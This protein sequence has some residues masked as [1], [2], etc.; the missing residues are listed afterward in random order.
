MPE[1]S[2]ARWYRKNRGRWNQ[3]RRERYHGD[4][5]FRELTLKRVRRS[6]AKTRRGEPSGPWTRCAGKPRPANRRLAPEPAPWNPAILCH[7]IGALTEATGL[8][9]ATLVGWERRGII[10]LPTFV[11]LAGKKRYRRYS[12]DY[13]RI[14]VRCVEKGRA[15]AWSTRR[16]SE[17]VWKA[18][19]RHVAKGGSHAQ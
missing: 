17:A 18:Y 5:E 4:T 3:K 7:G 1:W 9:K 16:F 2:F 13:L 14:L 19:Q 8:A 10:P 6:R 12:Q 11:E 15:E